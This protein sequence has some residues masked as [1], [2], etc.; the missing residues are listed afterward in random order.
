MVI[1]NELGTSADLA[2]LV[3]KQPTSAKVIK[4]TPAPK[5]EELELVA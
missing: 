5:A 2:F 3:T 1:T 4:F